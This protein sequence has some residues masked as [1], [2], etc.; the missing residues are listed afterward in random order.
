VLAIDA[1]ARLGGG[2]WTVRIGAGHEETGLEAAEWARKGA[3]LGAGEILLTS[4]DRDGTG[5]GF[6]LDL[7][8]AVS[9]ACSIPVIASGGAGSGAE[10]ARHF[11]DAVRSGARAVLAAGI[12]HRGEMT[13]GEVKKGLESEGIGARS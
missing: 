10:G 8:V 1:A 4:I 13:I 11:A 5:R 7:L 3:E 12:F 6:D 2:G 9:Q